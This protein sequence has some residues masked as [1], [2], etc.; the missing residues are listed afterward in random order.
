MYDYERCNYKTIQV[1]SDQNR[2]QQLIILSFD[3]TNN[4]IFEFF[5][6]SFQRF[7]FHHIQR[8]EYRGES[9]GQRCS[10][11]RRKTGTSRW[12]IRL[13]RH[14]F[15][16]VE[17]LHSLLSASVRRPFSCWRHPRSPE[18]V[19]LCVLRVRLSVAARWVTWSVAS[20]VIAESIC[21]CRRVS[22]WR[23]W[24]T[25]PDWWQPVYN[26]AESV[27]V[28]NRI[29]DG[30]HHWRR[31]REVSSREKRTTRRRRTCTRNGCIRCGARSHD[32]KCNRRARYGETALTYGSIGWGWWLNEIH[33]WCACEARVGS[34]FSLFRR[35][36]Q[37]SIH[38]QKEIQPENGRPTVKKH[39]H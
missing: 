1:R 11:A 39:S 27:V 12:A 36:L 37:R 17:R 28:R 6:F 29:R 22:R 2:K 5:V 10:Y 20:D 24:R 38:D 25:T 32:E 30:T 19:L 35:W 31:W 14:R 4:Y 21:L 23:R 15:E 7:W 8:C 26:R 34:P 18:M 33:C 16:N 13:L 9:H 3:V